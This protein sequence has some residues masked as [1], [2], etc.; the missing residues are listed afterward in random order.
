M[1]K[2]FPPLVAG[3]VL[4]LSL[5]S[6]AFAQHYTQVNLDSNTS[7]GAE[8]TDPQLVNAWG[9]ARSSG[10]TWWVSDEATGLATLYDGP[11]AK[12]SLVV[13]IPKSDPNDKKLSTGTPSGAI[14]NSSTT[15]FPAA[16]NKPA[17]FIF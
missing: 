10:S 12:Q 3:V 2:F 4:T 8:S 14:S 16:P 11:G 1:M 7:G 5:S 17:D 15:D 13:T 6:A 9:L